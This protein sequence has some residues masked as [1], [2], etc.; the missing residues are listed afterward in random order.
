MARKKT[1]ENKPTIMDVAQKKSNI[2]QN[3]FKMDDVEYT[4][5][6]TV[7]RETKVTLVAHTVEN[8]CRKVEEG[9]ICRDLLI[10]RTEGQWST[11]IKSMLIYSMLMDRQIGNILMATGRSDTQNYAVN[12]LI[13]G[14]QRTS[15][16]VDFVNNKFSLGKNT[17]S[18]ICRCKTVDG[19]EVEKEFPLAR[20]K[21]KHLPTGLQKKLLNYT[22]SIY[23]YVN[24]TDEELDE[25]VY[26]VNSGKAPTAYQ[27]MRFALGSENMREIQPICESTLW[28]DVSGCKTKN[29]SILPC[30]LRIL[31][32]YACYPYDSLGSAAINNFINDFEQYVTP[33]VIDDVKQLIEELAEVKFKL[34]DEELEFF[35]SCNIPHL[36]LGLFKFNNMDNP[37]GKSYDEFIKAFL[38]SESYQEYIRFQETSKGSGGSKYS[39]DNFDGRQS[40]IEE[41]ID[42]FL[43]CSLSQDT[44]T[45]VSTTVDGI[46]DN[47]EEVS[48]GDNVDTESGETGRR[49]K[50]Y[51]SQEI[52]P[53]LNL[54]STFVGV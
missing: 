10:Q 36:A 20:K 52:L 12:S 47:E 15:A 33:S 13:D 54:S 1:T 44:D 53:E 27:K 42:E 25:I 21:F 2:K 48:G 46:D 14:L 45:V 19:K 40:I 18:I 29:D 16:I 23:S 11:S 8:L 35:D 28:E 22:L 24:F 50:I 26:C 6:S 9:E 39:A 31:M 49:D 51:V 41:Y 30:I 32:G 38:K 34:T 37:D 7:E 17:P 5:V 43:D 3:T 4:F